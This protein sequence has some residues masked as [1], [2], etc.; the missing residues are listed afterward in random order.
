MAWRK[1]LDA[2]RADTS[3]R[4]REVRIEDEPGPGPVEAVDDTLQLISRA[5]RTVSPDFRSW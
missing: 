4:R 3:R 1:F 2:A 5:K